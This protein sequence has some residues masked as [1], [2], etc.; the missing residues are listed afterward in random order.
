MPPSARRAVH[1]TTARLG[2]V[3]ERHRRIDL[4]RGTPAQHVRPVVAGR[5][6]GAPRERIRTRADWREE[7]RVGDEAMT[8][9]PSGEE[10]ALRC[11]HRFRPA[12][13]HAERGETGRVG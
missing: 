4:G 13:A 2:A 1:R 5:F 7:V 6:D 12:R 10:R 9:S 3:G 11:A 8:L